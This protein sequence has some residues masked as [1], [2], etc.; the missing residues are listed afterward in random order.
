MAL[1]PNRNA[2]LYLSVIIFS[3]SIVF[4]IWA[5]DSNNQF[6]YIIYIVPFI[7]IVEQFL[8]NRR[9]LLNPIG[10]LFLFWAV[11]FGLIS[12]G[13]SEFFTIREIVFV[14]LS[15]GLASIKFKVSSKSI[16]LMLPIL[17]LCLL[18]IDNSEFDNFS[19]DLIE[20]SKGTYE[21]SLGLAIPILSLLYFYKKKW[22]AFILSLV[23]AFILG[24]RV[25]WLGLIVAFTYHYISYGSPL[26]KLPH[27]AILVRGSIVTVAL[28]A[29]LNS[30]YLFELI[31]IGLSKYFSVDISP[32]FLS[33][34]RYLLHIDINEIYKSSSYFQKIV[35]M[36]IGASTSILDGTEHG[37]LHNDYKRVLIDY[38][39]FGLMLGFLTSLSIG[40]NS[41]IISALIVYSSIIFMSDNAMTY[42]YFWIMLLI[43]IRC[44]SSKSV[45]TPNARRLN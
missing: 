16:S 14:V 3:V 13:V 35:G 23:L 15:L 30:V 19:V 24:K 6:R 11:I 21:H 26:R 4:Y 32:N 37:L 28:L 33:S 22:L 31:S 20:G 17:A 39:Y 5:A 8:R 42:L 41:Q 12:I 34:G 10:I 7:F 38:G 18:V 9:V 45:R 1:K 43:A 25:A 29:S 27:M 2:P 44:E 40:K 36:G